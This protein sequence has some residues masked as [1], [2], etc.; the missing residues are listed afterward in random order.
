MKFE[1]TEFKINL[2]GEPKP[3]KIKKPNSRYYK[4]KLKEI[5]RRLPTV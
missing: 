2:P 4:K 5:R 1:K 3:F